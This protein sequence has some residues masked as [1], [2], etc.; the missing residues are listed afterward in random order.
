MNGFSS[1]PINYTGT[2]GNIII[3]KKKETL[4]CTD[5]GPIV[6]SKRQSKL[7]FFNNSTGK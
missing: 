5:E 6:G 7:F 1:Y 4:V 2:H 3:S